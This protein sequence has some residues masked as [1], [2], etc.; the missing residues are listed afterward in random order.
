MV[1]Y[2]KQGKKNKQ[3]G[4][5]FERRTRKDLQEKG[6]IVDK[7]SSNVEFNCEPKYFTPKGIA[8]EINQ[9]IKI[10]K[11]IPCKHT[12]RGSGIPMA[13]GT[14]FPDFIAYR[15]SIKLDENGAR[16]IAPCI[17]SYPKGDFDYQI[18][19]IEC[20]TNGYLSKEEK[21]KAQWYLKNNYCSK[22]LIAFKTKI[23]NKVKVNYKEVEL[24]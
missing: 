7:W 21:E 20:K 2:V 24:K 12:F 19:F 5:D 4:A 23:K 22:F 14:G 11:L 3:M 16:I 8:T 10:G 17:P 9:F 15:I 6:W 13:I 1:D 18:Q